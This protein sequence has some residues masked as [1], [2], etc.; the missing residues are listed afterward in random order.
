VSGL[1]KLVTKERWR[2]DAETVAAS[3]ASLEIDILQ[4]ARSWNRVKA[5]LLMFA[6]GSQVLAVGLTAI[7]VWRVLSA[8]PSPP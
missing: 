2:D 8:P 1:R 4:Q 5:F 3:T 6:I 7:A